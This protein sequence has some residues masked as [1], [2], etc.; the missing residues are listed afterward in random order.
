MRIVLSADMEGIAGIRD[1]RELLA[2]CPAYWDSGRASFTRD[3]ASASAGLLEGGATE[4]IILDNHASGNP[5]NLDTRLLPTGARIATWNVFDLPDLDIDGMLQVGYHPRR[6]VPGFAPH[7]YIP[8]LRLWFDG[9]EISESHGRAWAAQAPLLG[10]VG[11]A[12]HGRTL[13]SLADAPFLAVQDG[14]DPHRPQPIFAA[15][16]ESDASI[17]SFARDAMRGIGDAPV[18]AAPDGGLFVASLQEPDDSQVRT[19]L[20]GGWS[21]RT[22]GSFES[23]LRRWADARELLAAAMNA[24]LAPFLEDL[25]ALELSC[26]EA[27]AAQSAN[28]RE[29][30]T[31]LFL[32]HLRPTGEGVR[33]G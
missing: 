23:Y 20:A 22:E 29:R 14:D 16:A 15:S 32:D 26:R 28:R 7:T 13:G 21:R 19:M 18:P 6:M 12:N 10:I 9:E 27:M 4:V 1:A 30:L 24:A 5:S 25:A 33:S 2:C 31:R 8:G 11:H 17:R 3:V